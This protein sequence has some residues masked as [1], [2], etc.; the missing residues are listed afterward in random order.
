[1]KKFNKK[2]AKSLTA[3]LASSVIAASCGGGG[4][5]SSSNNGN[6][7]PPKPTITTLSKKDVGNYLDGQY[8]NVQRNVPVEIGFSP[9]KDETCDF[10]FKNNND[11]EVC[12]DVNDNTTFEGYPKISIGK[13]RVGYFDREGKF[14][15]VD[16]LSKK[17]DKLDNIQ[18]RPSFSANFPLNMT[19]KIFDN[20]TKTQN[21]EICFNNPDLLDSVKMDLS[22][23]SSFYLNKAPDGC[24]VIPWEDFNDG[25]YSI[26]EVLFRDVNGVFT[27]LTSG[28]MD[29]G[30]VNFVNS[31]NTLPTA[32][33][34]LV[35]TY[36]KF[37]GEIRDINDKLEFSCV[38]N[39]KEDGQNVDVEL[40][41]KAISDSKYTTIPVT[42]GD[43]VSV[44][45]SKMGGKTLEVICSVTDS[46]NLTTETTEKYDIEKNQAPVYTGGLYDASG[47]TNQEISLP[48]AEFTDPEG[49]PI[50]SN[51]LSVSNPFISSVEGTFSYDA[52]ATDK[53]GAKGNSPIFKIYVKEST[54]GTI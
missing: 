44:D 37:N 42:N 28:K 18:Q 26:K 50:V 20:G 16:Q 23:N 39:D 19:L 17:I 8:S 52:T 2:I 22:D 34:K 7:I 15:S 45:I 13:N 32:E 27:R 41:Y 12:L 31:Y 54:N 47:Y 1:M 38:G 5:G 21:G 25:S 43:N 10:Y 24:Y 53:Y 35:G 9:V 33:L 48:T 11:V 6:V 4:G 40:K 29:L 30:K 49:D 3:I 46:G 36:K 14:T 51:V